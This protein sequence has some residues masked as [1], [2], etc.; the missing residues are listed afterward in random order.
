MFGQVGV[1]VPPAHVLDMYIANRAALHC[2]HC[3]RCAHACTQALELAQQQVETR[4][5]ALAAQGEALKQE[6]QEQ[7]TEHTRVGGRF[8]KGPPLPFPPLC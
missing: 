1:N 4:E 5:Q 7:L 3:L 6:Q 8:G 2:S